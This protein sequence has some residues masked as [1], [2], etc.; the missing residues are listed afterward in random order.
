MLAV[1]GIDDSTVVKLVTG[2]V[3]GLSTAIAVLYRSQQKQNED[4]R[5]KLD[6]CEEGH[7][8]TNTTILNLTEKVGN[9]EGRIAGITELSDRVIREIH[10]LKHDEPK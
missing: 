8:T 9:L 1:L 4:T 6:K 5:K 10:E 7:R 2:I 3:V